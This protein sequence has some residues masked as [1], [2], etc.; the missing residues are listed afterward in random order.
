MKILFLH[1]SDAHLK[2]DTNLYEINTN[3]LVNS[4]SQMG[5]FDECIMVFSG[6]IANSG[7]INEY[8]VAGKML[9][10]ILKGINEKYFD[11]QKY[12]QTLIVP[13]NHDNMSKNR[14]RTRDEI[15]SF[16]TDKNTESHFYDDLAE[17]S[18]FYNFSNRNNCFKRGKNIDVRTLKFGAFK[19]KVNLINSAPFS[20]LGSDNGDKG[21]HYF[22]MGDFSKFDFDNEENYTISIIHHSPEWFSEDSKKKLYNKL[23][24]STDLLFV[25]HEHFSLNENKTVNG[26]AIDVSSGVALYGTK[27]EHGFNALL[28]DT[29]Q[30]TLI[31]Y[32]YIYNGRIYKPSCEPV[33]E[34]KH[35]IFNGKYKFTHTLNFKNYLETDIEQ[36][37]GK[38]YLDYF[39]FPSLEDKN[40]NSRLDTLSI[41][42]EEKFMEVF[43]SHS[44]ISIEG[45]LK[46][47]KST[48]AKY[49]CLKLSMEYVP[50]LLTEYDFGSKNNKNVIK[51][52]LE[53][54]YGASADCDEFLQLDKEKRV[55]IVDRHDRVTKKR[56]DSFFEEYE[57][58]FGHIILF[59]GIDWNINIK[60]KALEELEE[61]E[62]LYLRIC[63]FYYAKREE[64]IQKICNSFQERNAS[65]TKE[66]IYKINEEI[67][68]QIRYFQL[69]PDFIHQYVNYYLNYSFMKTQ[70][71]NNV[72]NKVFEAN[73]TFRIAQ[74]TQEENVDE[75]RVALDF[76]AHYIHFNKKYPLPVDEFEIAINQYNEKYDNDINPKMVYDIAVASN[77]LN[78]VP[79][80]FGIEFC[81][82]NLLAYFTALHLNRG[83]NEGTCKEELKY[84]LNNICFEING[85]IILFLSYITSNIQILNPIMD[86]MINLMSEWDEFSFDKKNIEFLTRKTVPFIKQSVP[87]E[88][89]KKQNKE[90]KNE[91]ERAIIAEKKQNE[92]SLYSYDESKVNS[93]SNK[94]SSALSFLELVAKI[95]PNFRYILGGEKKREVVKILYTYPNKLLYFM[96]KDIDENID[97]IIDEI[98]S[99]NPKTKR[100]M[101]ITRE[102]LEKSLQS[103]AIAYILSIYDFVACT[104]SAGKGI[105]ELNK[106]EFEKN[107]NYLLQNIMME[108]NNG[109]FYTFSHK[110]EKM[111]D[112]TKSDML[113]NMIGLVVRKYF[114]NHDVVLSG[115]GQHFADK[116]FDADE[117]KDLKLL[118]AKNRI[119]KK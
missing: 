26:K 17:L 48:L 66:T 101:I 102:M 57:S 13:G 42:T 14:G 80:K 118:Q 106:F 51:Y 81:D 94:I 19:I 34:N 18:N 20:L 27:T 10:R 110:A 11:G 9:G 55:L 1:L 71:D 78:E 25:G 50:L 23:Y 75:I 88:K 82:E 87:D 24:D 39:V 68:N 16:Y 76:V 54:Q 5:D 85:D 103:Q 44:H 52:A 70:H 31:G 77:I 119:V 63:P 116:F 91:S 89:D 6:D 2:Q 61:K 38:H 53:E 35:I 58:Q 69:N 28:L 74:N 72:F 98:L 37:K 117:K 41:T 40:L 105:D 107:T 90:Q 111:Y 93:F 86:S 65:N 95:L 45:N 108:E 112:N 12:I 114:L 3:A 59:C 43:K 8:K 49:L 46:A 99:K 4:L 79:D 113:K 104:A 92:E 29:D 62:V 60:E 97:R 36:W 7:S 73:I 115:T 33:L 109:N 32:K 83:L 84:I 56:W 15:T 100:G 30:A 22:P 21:L 96:L 47:G 67:T 64:L